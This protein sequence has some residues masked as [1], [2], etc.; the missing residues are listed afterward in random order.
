[1]IYPDSRGTC[2]SIAVCGCTSSRQNTGIATHYRLNKSQ[3]VNVLH[4]HNDLSGQ[5]RYMSQVHVTVLEFVDARL[6]VKT[7]ELRLITGWI[8]VK[9]WMYYMYIMIYPDSRGTC[10]SI[11]V[12]GCTSSRQ[13][14][15]IA[16]HY[17]LNKRQNVKVLHEHNDLSGQSRYMSQY[18]SLWMHVFPSK[19]WNCDSLQAE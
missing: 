4:E 15:G 7:L 17:R 8:K 13:N 10:R 3:N 9:M 6:P 5:S 16:T 2:R 18:W 12:C 1:M 14:T 19:H 11:G